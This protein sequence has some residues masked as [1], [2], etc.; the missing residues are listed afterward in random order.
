MGGGRS[1][2]EC[3]HRV[4][5]DLPKELNTSPWTPEEDAILMGRR[6]MR[7]NL[8]SMTE[9]LRKYNRS[10]A[11]VK[12]RCEEL[13]WPVREDVWAPMVGP[14]GYVYSGKKGLTEGQK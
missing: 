7:T 13:G 2:W 12:K 1:G 10:G 11:A 8:V 9:R 4:K 3:K 14:S 5:T 6:Q